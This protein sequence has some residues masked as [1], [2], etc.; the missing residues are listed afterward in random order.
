M[1]STNPLDTLNF[2]SDCGSFVPD[3]VT[4]PQRRGALLGSSTMPWQLSTL[5]ARP[6]EGGL[7]QCRVRV[8][9]Q[10]APYMVSS[11]WRQ[12]LEWQVLSA[13][14]PLGLNCQGLVLKEKEGL[15]GCML[16]CS[17]RSLSVCRRGDGSG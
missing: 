9:V 4:G 6:L 14:Y 13:Y 11:G 17:N 1:P 7:C 5:S 8:R 3:G 10:K 2:S 16:G 15:Y 12:V